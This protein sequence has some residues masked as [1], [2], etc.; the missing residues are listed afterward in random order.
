MKERKERAEKFSLKSSA[1]YPGLCLLPSLSP[2]SNRNQFSVRMAFMRTSVV[3]FLLSLAF[4]CG[5][6]LG[7][8]LPTDLP[9]GLFYRVFVISD[10]RSPSDLLPILQETHDI[11]KKTNIHLQVTGIEQRP[12]HP[13]FNDTD[14]YEAYEAVVKNV[15]QDRDSVLILHSS[16]PRSAK[17]L[18]TPHLAC[19]TESFALINTNQAEDVQD[20]I[21]SRAIAG[22]L[23]K[24]LL[25][26]HD[27]LNSTTDCSCQLDSGSPANHTLC[28]SD[29]DQ[30]LLNSDGICSCYKELLNQVL[31][32]SVAYPGYEG[33]LDCL[34]LKPN[35]STEFVIRG[36]GIV[37]G[38]EG[39][40]CTQLDPQCCVSNTAPG[41]PTSGPSGTESSNVTPEGQSGD[42]QSSDSTYTIGRVIFIAVLL[43]VLMPFI[44]VIVYF[45]IKKMNHVQSM[46]EPALLHERP[47]LVVG[48][49]PVLI[50]EE[51]GSIPVFVEAHPIVQEISSPIVED[52]MFVEAPLEV[53]VAP[54]DDPDKRV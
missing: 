19:H 30:F 31:L 20:H 54:Q 48:Q 10:G 25:R 3:V 23:F 34:K 24:I 29:D 6:I 18:L 16:M 45:V 12:M 49:E 44:G 47:T 9:S 40:D 15:T 5:F 14:A 52:Q 32:G 8:Q 33:S 17:S 11:L 36:N 53:I 51:T 50:V 42:N 41:I 26:S 39:C 46:P 38:D 27:M 13:Y 1:L 2:S 7:Q 22:S 37:E 43:L 35:V 28:L 21:Q 4:G